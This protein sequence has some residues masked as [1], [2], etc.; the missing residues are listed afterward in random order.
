MKN[1]QQYIAPLI[2]GSL[3]FMVLV[4]Y[5]R[6]DQVR[7]CTAVEV[8]LH[9]KARVIANMLDSTVKS[10]MKCGCV[11][12]KSFTQM[13][14]YVTSVTELKYIQLFVDGELAL[15]Y[16][17]EPPKFIDATTAEGE[18]ITCSNYYYWRE[19]KWSDIN[20]FNI[21]KTGATHILLGFP[22]E[23]CKTAH[24]IA[25]EQFWLTVLIGLISLFIFWL[26]TYF[27][28]KNIRLKKRVEMLQVHKEQ[29]LELNQAATG[30]AHETKNPLGIIRGL[31]QRISQNS[32]D[33]S[34]IEH[35]A[36]EIV[37]Q[38]DVTA[39][40]LADFMNYARFSEVNKTPL[41][42]NEVLLPIITVISQDCDEMGVNFKNNLKQQ[43]VLADK[44][45]ISQIATNLLFNSLKAVQ[46]NDTIS[47][48]LKEDGKNYILEIK[49]TGKGIDPG[50]MGEI[51]KPYV[52]NSDG[53]HGIGLSVVKRC[54]NTLDWDIN[55]ESELGVGTTM[56]ITGIK[57]AEEQSDG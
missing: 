5:A 2:I 27:T 49:D 50:F 10:E 38:A 6:K 12:T 21:G 56:T 25:S 52:S 18:K 28:I 43:T 48:S 39:D 19:V 42:L 22:L 3:F 8:Q 29:L 11:E 4:Y 40:R 35:V 51:F 44:Q 57:P 46:S 55:V 26:S 16:P 14:K 13:I 24:K 36:Q 15:S 23:K 45:M 17:E 9:D 20:R 41:N 1:I 37:E 30:L 53:G 33:T 31:A 47:I 54:I 7:S 34:S 32:S